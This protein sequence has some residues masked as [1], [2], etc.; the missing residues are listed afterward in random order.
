MKHTKL[1]TKTD[2]GSIKASVVELQALESIKCSIKA[3]LSHTNSYK[4]PSALQ[5][6]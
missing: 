4:G 3:V 1:S 6:A 5:L 2:N